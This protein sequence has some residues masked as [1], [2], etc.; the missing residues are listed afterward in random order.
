MN[1]TEFIDVYMSDW[2]QKI[3]KEDK[4][5]MLM[6]EFNINL[7]KYDTNAWQQSNFRL[8]VCK[9]FP[10]ISQAQHGLQHTQN[11]HW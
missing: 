9:F 7:L 10:L 8:D 4:T 1:S 6:G 5:I 3:S 11:T 2:L